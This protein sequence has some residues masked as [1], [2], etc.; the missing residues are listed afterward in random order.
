MIWD[1]GAAHVAVLQAALEGG[2]PFAG[3]LCAAVV[4]LAAPALRAPESGRTR[5]VLAQGAAAA[6]LL[7]LL[8]SFG[9]IALNVP[10]VAAFAALLLG[11]VWSNAVS[12][13][14]SGL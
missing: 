11:A 1:F 3:L 6:S 5:G 12:A 10:A 7:A 2:L 4:M 9:D 14:Q 13:D 8:C